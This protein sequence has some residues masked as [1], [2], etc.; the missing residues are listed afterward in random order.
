MCNL[1]LAESRSRTIDIHFSL[2]YFWL[3]SILLTSLDLSSSAS[4][5]PTSSIIIGTLWVSLNFLNSIDSQIARLKFLVQRYQVFVSI[6]RGNVRCMAT[7]SAPV[8]SQNSRQT[9]FFPTNFHTMATTKNF[10]GVLKPTEN[11]NKCH[12]FAF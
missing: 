10:I 3:F 8:G 11:D 5:Y 6:M 12:V 7:P 9:V 2:V 4:H 1:A